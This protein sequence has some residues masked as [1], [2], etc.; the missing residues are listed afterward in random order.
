MARD[1]LLYSEARGG[2]SGK[3]ARVNVNTWVFLKM[4]SEASLVLVLVD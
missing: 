4:A 2:V 3:V 1:P